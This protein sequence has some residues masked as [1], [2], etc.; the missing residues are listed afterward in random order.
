MS[1]VESEGVYLLS[2]Q[3]VLGKKIYKVGRSDNLKQRLG[4][5]PPNWCLLDCLPCKNSIGVERELIEKFKLKFKIYSRN[6]YFECGMDCREVKRIFNNILSEYYSGKKRGGEEMDKPKNKS[7]EKNIETKCEKGEKDKMKTLL[8]IRADQLNTCEGLMR[9]RD[10]ELFARDFNAM[11]DS[12]ISSKDKPTTDRIK[13]ISDSLVGIVSKKTVKEVAG[14]IL[15]EGAENV[16]DK[17]KI[18]K[19]DIEHAL[20]N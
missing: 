18:T 10:L 3:D 7:Q 13:V 15:K 4:S 14:T 20:K 17:I 2:S 1:I 12:V 6:E 19:N 9:K 16:T 11:I 8:K 5:Y